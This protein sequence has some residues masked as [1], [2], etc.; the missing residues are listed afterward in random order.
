MSAG[1]QFASKTVPATAD[2]KVGFNDPAAIGP[3]CGWDERVVKVSGIETTFNRSVEDGVVTVTVDCDDPAVLLLARK[4][5]AE[6]WS[7]IWH[8]NNRDRRLWASDIT[9]QMLEEG[10]VATDDSDGV[11]T[12]ATAASSTGS[13]RAT[14]RGAH[15][16][17]AVVAQIRGLRLIEST[18]PATGW[19]TKLG[20]Y[21]IPGA[22]RRLLDSCFSTARYVYRGLP[23]PSWC[24]EAVRTAQ[25]D[26][27]VTNGDGADVFVG[28]NGDPVVA[29]VDRNPQRWSHPYESSVDR[30]LGASQTRQRN[31]R[32][33]RVV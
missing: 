25:R 1:G 27:Y 32:R 23:L 24:T 4:G 30:P 10:L 9:R 20:G 21:T 6:Y 26:G 19:A 8:K 12:A 29:C 3:P 16:L 18:A 13:R 5:D 22:E 31:D 2:N 14:M 11:H 15:A 33:S 28:E 17:T 7:V